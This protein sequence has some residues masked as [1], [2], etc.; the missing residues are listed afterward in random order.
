MKKKT[1]LVVPTI[2]LEGYIE[3]IEGKDKSNGDFVAVIVIRV[4]DEDDELVKVTVVEELAEACVDVLKEGDLIRVSGREK[5]ERF[6]RKVV[7]DSV[8]YCKT[9]EEL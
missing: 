2:T 8:I 4:E 1:K 3:S 6:S 9:G 7:A 5:E